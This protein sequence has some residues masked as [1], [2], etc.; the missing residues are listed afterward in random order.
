MRIQLSFLLISLLIIA[1]CNMPGSSGKYTID[2]EIEGMTNGEVFLMR[3]MDG[4]RKVVDSALIRE[5]RFHFEGKMANPERVYLRFGDK[6]TTVN[7]FL[8]NAAVQVDC[9]WDSL[10]DA[11]VTGS[12]SHDEFLAFEESLKPFQT[13]REAL[14]SRYRQIEDSGDEEAK[15]QIE[16]SIDSIDGISQDFTQNYV[17]QHGTSPVSAYIALRDLSLQADA[18]SLEKL[19][20]GFTLD[21][22]PYIQEMNKLLEVKRRVGIGK[23][24]PDFAL[25]GPDGN[26]ISLSDFK[27]KYV[28]VDF[29]ASWCRP[30]RVENPNVVAMYR[31]L[32]GPDFEILGVSFDTDREKWLQA[33]EVDSLT[34]PHVSDLKGWQSAAG[35]IYGVKSIPHTVLINK[36]GIIIEKN[37][38]GDALRTHMTSL[39]KGS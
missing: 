16:A 7:F 34:W 27:G 19:I 36:E 33:I 26:P 1:A 10:G 15:K 18:E 29:W 30:C 5:K 25:E 28:L 37:L 9:S 20:A 12:P 3:F 14:I 24:A 32:A 11:K 13:Q 2:G 38:R 31:E 17:S 22:N 21:N 6:G 8:E 35:E 39:L 23:V 4:Q